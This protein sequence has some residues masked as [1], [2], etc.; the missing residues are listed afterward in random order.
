VPEVTPS[1]P[2]LPVPPL[3]DGIEWNGKPLPKSA[4]AK[5]NAMADCSLLLSFVSECKQLDLDDSFHPAI[6]YDQG[7]VGK[8]I[9]SKPISSQ[10]SSQCDQTHIK[11][12][13]HD[14]EVVSS[15]PTIVSWSSFE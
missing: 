10:S 15:M 8:L 6:Y 3:L 14:R 12:G 11:A 9:G 1:A 2:V 4:G 13:R 5:T 7:R